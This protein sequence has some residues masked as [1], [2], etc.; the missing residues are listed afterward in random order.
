NLRG[1]GHKDD[2]TP[3]LPTKVSGSATSATSVKITMGTSDA[4]SGV[5][6]F[7]SYYRDNGGALVHWAANKA[8]TSRVGTAAYYTAS[9]A[10]ASGHS[11]RVQARARD[12][13][14]NWGDWGVYTVVT[15]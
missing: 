9:F 8:P 13:E 14:G 5:Q 4:Q 10:A 7:D 15:P 2:L 6:V 12:R 3:P 1:T 11:Y